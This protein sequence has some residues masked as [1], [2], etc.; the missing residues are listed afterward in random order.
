MSDR[1]EIV[2]CEHHGKC[3]ATYVCRHMAR[4]ANR[5]FYCST[6]DD[7]PQP[8][9]WCLKCDSLLR[10]NGWEWND[11]IEEYADIMLICAHCYDKVKGRNQT[12]LPSIEDEGWELRIV[13]DEMSDYPDMSPPSRE[14]LSVIKV[15]DLV[16]VVFRILGE[17]ENGA[18]T[19][20]ERMWVKVQERTE[21]GY[22]G[23]LSNDPT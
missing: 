22:I 4:G 6:E 2:E 19:Q 14:E 8:D 1:K 15:G 3:Y 16:K 10:A 12:F 18:Y 13:I 21:Q 7:D 9:A 11:E 20:D 23:T 17:D 5:G